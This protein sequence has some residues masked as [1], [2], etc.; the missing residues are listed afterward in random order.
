MI[1]AARDPDEVEVDLGR[2]L[3][4]PLL[5]RGTALESLARLGELEHR[6]VVVHLV[7]HVF[8][9]ADVLPMP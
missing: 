8:V 5:E 2:E 7:D 1:A 9:D 4:A 3:L 6:V